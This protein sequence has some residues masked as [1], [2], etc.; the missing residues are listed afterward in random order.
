MLGKKYVFPFTV[1]SDLDLLIESS[2]RE[3]SLTIVGVVEP[4]VYR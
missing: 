3:N 2:E 1:D 4:E